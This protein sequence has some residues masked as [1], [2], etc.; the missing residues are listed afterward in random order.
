MQPMLFAIINF[1]NNE[2]VAS[3]AIKTIIDVTGET[4]QTWF[5][6]RIL[7]VLLEMP[8]LVMNDTYFFLRKR[9]IAD[10]LNAMFEK[11]EGAILSSVSW[12]TI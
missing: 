4:Y 9:E 11:L 8:Q 5:E 6:S 10:G 2:A 7:G 12:Q 1:R 3:K